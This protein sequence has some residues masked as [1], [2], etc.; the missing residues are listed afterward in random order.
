MSS[1]QLWWNGIYFDTSHIYLIAICVSNNKQYE[2][3]ALAQNVPQTW[4]IHICEPVFGSRRSLEVCSEIKEGLVY[5]KTLQVRFRKTFFFSFYPPFVYLTHCLI[6]I[7]SLHNQNLGRVGLTHWNQE[8]SIEICACVS[9]IKYMLQ[10]RKM[11]ALLHY[12]HDQ[13]ERH[14]FATVHH[15]FHQR[16]RRKWFFVQYIWALGRWCP[17]QIYVHPTSIW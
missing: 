16:W 13:A 6:H 15:D 1:V 3:F 17:S 14:S 9:N 10:V 5:T 11:E 2:S 7:M 12:I 8:V 4:H